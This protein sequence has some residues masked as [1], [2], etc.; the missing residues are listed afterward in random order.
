[1]TSL[2]LD[3]AK[4][5]LNISVDTYDEELSDVISAAEAA[6]IARIGPL[7]VTTVTARVK[8]GG[9]GTLILPTVPAVSL[10][11]VASRE[12]TSLDTGTLLLDGAAGTIECAASCSWFGSVAYDVT[13]EAGYDDVPADLLFAV[14]ELVRHLWTTQRGGSTRPG[15][16]PTESTPGYFMP[17]RVMELLEPYRVPRVS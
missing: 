11:S 14:K 8:G 13:Y 9:R 16:A 10:I 5:H 17:N 6:I 3:E 12:G 1:M 4:A 15:S 2:S 7:E